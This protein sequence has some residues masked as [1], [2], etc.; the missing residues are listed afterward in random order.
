[1]V[2][3]AVELVERDRGLPDVH[4]ERFRVAGHGVGRLLPIRLR[5]HDVRRLHGQTRELPG[6]A[7]RETEMGEFHRRR[8]GLLAGPPLLRPDAQYVAGQPLVFA[9][10]APEDGTHES[11]L[12]VGVD[13]PGKAV[14]QRGERRVQRAD[15]GGPHRHARDVVEEVRPHVRHAAPGAREGIVRLIHRRTELL[16]RG[17]EAL[18]VRDRFKFPREDPADWHLRLGAPGAAPVLLGA[19][20]R[21]AKL[22]ALLPGEI[23]EALRDLR[24]VRGC[25][26]RLGLR[27]RRLLGRLGVPEVAAV[28]GLL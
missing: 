20:P 27:E 7:A 15:G 3:D 4:P 19:R 1:M 9:R 26:R 11:H 12:P 8:H 17:I 23:P 10:S 13:G 21:L 5:S 18:D 24:I 6:L 22:R 14:L 28:H 25:G 2:R 16:A